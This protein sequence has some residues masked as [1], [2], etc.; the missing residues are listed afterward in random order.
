MFWGGVWGA[1]PLEQG[2]FMCALAGM[3]SRLTARE[4][5]ELAKLL[6][7][8][9]TKLPEDYELASKWL[10]RVYCIQKKGENR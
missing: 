3:E 8:N 5:D 2:G 6:F 1:W 9:I 4:R 10:D 7:P